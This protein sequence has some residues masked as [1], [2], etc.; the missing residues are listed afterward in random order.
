MLRNAT[1]NNLRRTGS[2][3]A[4]I[5][6]LAAS[7]TFL[8]SAQPSF[9]D[10]N[11]V[12]HADDDGYF[13][14]P[15]IFNAILNQHTIVTVYLT[16]GNVQ[17]DDY[18]YMH[19]REHGSLHEYAGMALGANYMNRNGY[20]EI[21]SAATIDTIFSQVN[22][23]TVHWNISLK[24]Y[25]G[26]K[27]TQ[28][29][30]VESSCSN[31][32]LIFMRFPSAASITG[33]GI[34]RSLSGNT[35]SPGL[36]TLNTMYNGGTGLTQAS[37]DS[38]ANYTKANLTSTLEAV[39]Q[40]FNPT[41]IRCQDF[42]DPITTTDKTNIYYDHDDHQWAAHFAKDAADNYRATGPKPQLWYYR[43]Y[44]MYTAPDPTVTIAQFPYFVRIKYWTL[45][46]YSFYDYQ[47]APNLY[48][49]QTSADLL[50]SYATY[51]YTPEQLFSG[52]ANYQGAI[53]FY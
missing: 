2:K 42:V 51:S 46:Y 23:D 44:G 47:M 4:C 27:V 20:S 31:I 10:L 45:Y 3:V 40:S 19:E 15:D 50:T 25:G 1:K 14:N 29:D 21:A 7:A 37:V 28:A 43:G 17:L 34:Y 8:A 30:C 6:I 52:P 53:R 32:H 33:Q 18:F 48:Q 38:L 13:M 24:Q 41:V 36:Q 5:L 11:I 12:A 26:V 39:M 16:S 9:V 35:I 22:P 49:Y